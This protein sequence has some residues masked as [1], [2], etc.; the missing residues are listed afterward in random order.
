MYP[1][2]D[3]ALTL[4]ATTAWWQIVLSVLGGVLVAGLSLFVLYAAFDSVRSRRR[5]RAWSPV[6]PPEPDLLAFP[7]YVDRD[8]LR[9]LAADLKI[10]LPLSHEV[11][12]SRRFS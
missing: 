5:M 4:V 7:Y 11:T 10:E 6:P 1:H 2:E 8:G 9:T 12:K 3:R